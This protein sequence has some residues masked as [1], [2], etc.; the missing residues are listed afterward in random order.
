VYCA[1]PAI[2]AVGPCLLYIKWYNRDLFAVQ[3]TAD[4]DAFE[5]RYRIT[6]PQLLFKCMTVLFSVLLG[7]F[8]HP[9]IHIS[10]TMV[11]LIGAIALL[12]LHSKD[13]VEEILHTVEWETLIFFASLFVLTEACAELGVLNAIAE[14][15]AEV[16][17]GVPIESRNRV[18]ML[19]ILWV[20]AI[21]SAFVD[22]IPFV[23][24]MV[25]VV[26]QLG[27][28][29]GLS[30]K[31]LAYSLCLGADF[32]GLGTLIGAG[33]NVVTAGVAEKAG[34]HISFISFMKV[35]MPIMLMCVVI[36]TF[37]LLFL[38]NVGAFPPSATTD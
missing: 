31:G 25:P 30:V 18:A 37:W 15:L 36:S 34:Y 35:G 12:L 33:A 11:A 21:V 10:P 26:M 23:T 32:G 20:S 4:I 38:E 19:L 9:V 16:I 14:E 27:N 2:M 5:G 29:E 8:L 6:K 22:N 7:F 3:I 24:A 13:E 28:V 1:P 17:E